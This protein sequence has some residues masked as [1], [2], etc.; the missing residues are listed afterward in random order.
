MP[1]TRESVRTIAR[2]LATAPRDRQVFSSVGKASGLSPVFVEEAFSRVQR[3]I[4]ARIAQGLSN[5]QI[6]MLEAVSVDTVLAMRKLSR[7]GNADPPSLSEDRRGSPALTHERVIEVLNK[8][9]LHCRPASAIATL[10]ARFRSDVG[11]VVDDTEIN[12]KSISGIMLGGDVGER[13]VFRATGDDAPAA[14]DALETLFANRFGE[15]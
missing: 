3:S 14:L 10:A 5:E 11:I 6:A 9:G 15:A 1:L 8:R 2:A 4:T 12:A 13:V 7:G